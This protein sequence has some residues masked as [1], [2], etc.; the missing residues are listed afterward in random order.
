MAD[1]ISYQSNTPRYKLPN[2]FAGQAQ[3]EFFVNE[4]HTLTDI[5]LHPAIEAELNDPPASPANGTC[6]LVGPG[7]GGEWGEH[8][9]ELASWQSGDW[10]FVTPA[11][12][13]RIRDNSTG[14][15]LY[16]DGS[17]R[18]LVAPAEPNGGNTIDSEARLAIGNLIATL[19]TAGVFPAI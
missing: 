6:W 14:G 18:R 12:G 11:E 4:V 16:F 15:M 19:R 8:S 5:L 17:W 2:L 10:L 3:K 9:G 1:P 7:A 13:L